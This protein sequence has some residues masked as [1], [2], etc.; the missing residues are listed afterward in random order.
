MKP[1]N[2]TATAPSRKAPAR[3]AGDE[4]N[5]PAAAAFGAWARPD[6]SS[7]PVTEWYACGF[8]I[9]IG[10]RWRLADVGGVGLCVELQRTTVTRKGKH[11]GVGKPAFFPVRQ[12][13]DLGSNIAVTMS[14]VGR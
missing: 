5:K 2:Y 6:G 9:K 12:L 11:R 4:C 7:R 3:V 14:K 1:N 13:A 10:S 8:K